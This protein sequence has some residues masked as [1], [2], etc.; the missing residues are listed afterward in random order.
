MIRSQSCVATKS[1][2]LV[3]GMPLGGWTAARVMLVRRL[4]RAVA[5]TIV[6]HDRRFLL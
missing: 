3:D 4:S 2:A 5:L 1:Q 6:S